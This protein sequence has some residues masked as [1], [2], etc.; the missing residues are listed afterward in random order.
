MNESDTPDPSTPVGIEAAAAAARRRHPLRVAALAAGVI[1]G[2]GGLLAVLVLDAPRYIARWVADHYL[3]GMEIDVEGVKTI[4]IDLPEG[5]FSFGPVR[6]HAG[7]A[8]PGTIGLLGVQLSLRNLFEKQALLKRVIVEDVDIAVRQTAEGELLINGVSLRQILAEKAEK[9]EKAE[10]QAEQP[11]PQPPASSAWGAGVDDLGLRDIVVTFV[12]RDGGSARLAVEH[13]DLQ[14]FR[15]WEPEQPGSFDLSADINGV[16]VTATGTARPFAEKISVDATISV[17]GV[18]L[19][20]VETYTG[21]LQLERAAGSASL[22]GRTAA[23]LFPDGRLEGTVDATLSAAGIDFAQRG[24]GEFLFGDAA[25][26]TTGGRFTLGSAGELA[27]KGAVELKLER[28]GMRL[29]DGTAMELNAGKLALA[30]VDLSRAEDGGLAV[31]TGARLEGDALKVDGPTQAEASRILLDVPRLEIAKS[32]AGAMSVQ[33]KPTGEASASHAAHLELGEPSSGKPVRFSAKQTTL[34]LASLSLQTAADGKLTA[35]STASLAADGGSLELDGAAGAPGPA[36]TFAALNAQAG[37]VAVD[38]DGGRMKLASRFAAQAKAFAAMLPAAGTAPAPAPATGR[39]ARGRTAAK[40]PAADTAQRLS[41]DG[42]DLSFPSVRMETA[43]AGVSVNAEGGVRIAKPAAVLPAD[44]ART[45]ASAASLELSLS[46][47]KLQTAAERTTMGGGGV[48]TVAGVQATAPQPGAAPWAVALSRAKLGFSGLDATLAPETRTTAKLDLTVE[49]VAA[50]QTAPATAASSRPV[51][52]RTGAADPSEARTRIAF[53]TLG[54]SLTPIELQQRSDR[55]SVRASGRTQMTA[56]AVELPRTPQ[57]PAAIAGVGSARTDLSEIRFDQAGPKPTWSARVN[58][59]ADK[60][61]SKVEGG[62]LASVDL[63]SVSIGDLQADDK[64]RLAIDRVVLDRLQAFLT[65]AYLFASATQEKSRPQEAVEAVQTAAE[66]GWRFR[67]ASASLGGNSAIRLRDTSIEPPTNATI[68]IRSLQ[69]LNL[70]TG[71]PKQQTQ[72]RLDATINEFTELGIAGWAAPFGGQ[73]DFDLNAR[74]RRL[75]LPPLSAY[76]AEAIGVNVESGRMSLDITAAATAGNL[77]GLL[78]LTLRDLDFSALSAADA[79]RLSASAGV[80]IG[81][82]VGL[83][84]DD[85]GRIRLRLPISGNLASPSFDPSDAIRQALTG[86]L[87]AAVLAPFQLAFAPVALLAKAAGGGSGKDGLGLQPIPFAADEAS[88]DSTAR[89]M[90]LGLGRVLQE[91]DKLKIKVC[92]RATSQ[93]LE[94]AL[95]ADGA[96]STGPGRAAAAERLA[97][98]L[99]SLAGQRTANVRSAIIDGG[100]AKPSPGRRMPH[101]LRPC[102]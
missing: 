65:R 6:F 27:F 12:N 82:V 4:D 89:D 73:P 70:N 54:V 29:A 93:D 61:T 3:T 62:S 43:A 16:E 33:A 91:R 67:I 20:S 17:D 8:D 15:S 79:E 100:G 2:V 18:D 44:G 59:L 66:E 52:G 21:P 63:Q 38:L 30:D 71:D 49:G 76:A 88:L 13:L 60:L 95:R 41:A 37:N 50:T 24:T 86:A 35:S 5:R 31:S 78:D 28:S 99:W 101:P 47:L 80:P 84:Q 56:L 40:P 42:I 10:Q 1:V 68:D 64:R 97:P 85:E 36:I 26:A 87:Q 7:G 98:E 72:L 25:L 77:N 22:R 83:L 92:G 90:A 39:G 58:I 14:D 46:P 69:V 23:T 19:K 53:E 57:N 45:E 48:L 9:A 51:R 34:D 102:R 96:P 81:T 55:L 11:T 75:E 94:A 74:L 32:P